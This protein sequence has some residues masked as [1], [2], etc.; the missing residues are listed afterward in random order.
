[1]PPQ[2]GIPI[3]SFSTATVTPGV[4]ESSTPPVQV[5]T[6]SEPVEARWKRTSLL[7]LE[8]ALQHWF[9]KQ[10]QQNKTAAGSM[11]LPEF[12]ALVKKLDWTSSHDEKCPAMATTVHPHDALVLN[13][14]FEERLLH[15]L[16]CVAASPSLQ[17]PLYSVDLDAGTLAP[18]PE[19]S[20]EKL[21]QLLATAK[22]LDALWSAKISTMISTH[23]AD[24]QDKSNK[25]TSLLRQQGATSNTTTAQPVIQ[26]IITDGMTV[27]Q[28]V[29]ARA[30]A[31][32]QQEQLRQDQEQQH[33]QN[34]HNNDRQWTILL[35]DALWTHARS[36]LLRQNF[37]LPNKLASHSVLLHNHQPKKQRTSTKCVMTFKDI[38]ATIAKSHIGEASSIQIA[39]ALAELETFTPKFVV[40]M[41]EPKSQDKS[42]SFKWPPTTTIYVA[43]DNYPAVRAQL[44]GIPL[45]NTQHAK[46]IGNMDNTNNTH[47]QK[48]AE[49][50]AATTS[51]TP[52]DVSAAAP[53]AVVSTSASRKRPSPVQAK[54]LLSDFDHT[55]TAAEA[56]DNDAKRIKKD[57]PTA[58]ARTRPS[59][60]SLC[61]SAEA[62]AQLKV[63]SS[64]ALSSSSIAV[65]TKKRERDSETSSSNT[66]TAELKSPT[67]TT[68][69]PSSTN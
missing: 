63:S 31:K 34:I 25:K 67:N 17:E 27:D 39:K 48:A 26:A 68:S 53:A 40:I 2:R 65:V 1:M 56:T 3:P 28:R 10:Q 37:Q 21:K 20:M 41:K 45:A 61:R 33:P 11:T 13:L 52:P 55:T 50:V 64:D 69:P 18:R 12:F 4:P 29:R 49:T 47:Q 38:V 9:R 32:Q 8:V 19:C 15:D 22:T 16:L 6:M 5:A 59:L 60:S 36:I 14:S 35:A 43:P 7:Q 58:P 42:R 51:A 30:K 54:N 24:K 44:T 57:P 23:R 46:I 66:A 62:T